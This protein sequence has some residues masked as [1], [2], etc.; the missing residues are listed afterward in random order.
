[1]ARNWMA[2][3]MHE[4]CKDAVALKPPSANTVHNF[5]VGTDIL[6]FD[7]GM[8]TEDN[9]A[10]VLAAAHDTKKGDVIIE[11]HAGDVQIVGVT[12]AHLTAQGDF[13]FV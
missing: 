8:F 9:A 1:M 11:T 10:A 2:E 5:D 13:V 6:Q 12:L 3:A 4:R 7:S